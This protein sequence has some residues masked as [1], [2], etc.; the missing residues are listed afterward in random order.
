MWFDNINIGKRI[1]DRVFWFPKFIISMLLFIVGMG[2]FIY[3][4][5]WIDEKESKNLVTGTY[6]VDS[7]MKD[8][9]SFSLE[10]IKNVDE[11]TYNSL[12]DSYLIL[13]D[14]DNA[15]LYLDGKAS[16]LKYSKTNDGINIGDIH[17][18]IYR[19]QLFTSFKGYDV[20][21]KFSSR[22]QI[23]ENEDNNVQNNVEED[24]EV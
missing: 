13:K 6:K 17:F 24:S 18:E 10:E 22:S 11:N 19:K 21:F 9:S 16:I 4:A 20:Y 2:A 8:G 1:V 7:V 12:V 15:Y 23:L 3:M 5:Y 14:G